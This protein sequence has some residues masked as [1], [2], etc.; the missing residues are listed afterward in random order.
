MRNLS[1]PYPRFIDVALPA[2]LVAGRAEGDAEPVASDEGPF[3]AVPRSALGVR[4]V[5]PKWVTEH[6]GEV[7]V[8]DV[9]QPDEFEGALGHLD[10]AELVPLAT[11]LRKATEWDREAPIVT[12][13]RS[14]GRSDRA[15]LALESLGF[16]NVASMVGGMVAVR[17]G[18]MR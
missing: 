14:S 13:C 10:A 2:N 3:A 7:R 4:H 12:V 8:V 11:L 16:R 15:A 1:L 6:Q 9:R 5:T 18:V 17:E